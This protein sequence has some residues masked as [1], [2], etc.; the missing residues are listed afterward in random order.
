MLNQTIRICHR[1]SQAK[2]RKARCIVYT[3]FLAPSRSCPPISPIGWNSFDVIRSLHA[4]LTVVGKELFLS[5]LSRKLPKLPKLPKLQAQSHSRLHLPISSVEIAKKMWLED[6]VTWF[7]QGASQGLNC[8]LQVVLSSHEIE[9]RVS[10][11]NL[12]RPSY[13]RRQSF[14]RTQTVAL[15]RVIALIAQGQSGNTGQ[16]P[17]GRGQGSETD[18]LRLSVFWAKGH[19]PFALSHFSDTRELESTVVAVRR[20]G[21]SRQKAKEK[22]CSAT[23]H[24]HFSPRSEQTL[25][26][27]CCCFRFQATR[28][29]GSTKHD[30]CFLSNKHW[31]QP[32]GRKVCTYIHHREDEEQIG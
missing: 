15:L 32:V 19:F 24:H 18:G 3:S 20:I 16:V 29:L 21:Q 6:M 31:L 23:R 22:Q 4:P 28:E 14:E 10:M 27:L 26:S 13:S 1:Q 12:L 8:N 25:I 17:A 30:H 9:T 2:A 7:R 11:A 5:S